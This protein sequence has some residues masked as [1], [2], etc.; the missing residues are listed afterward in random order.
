MDI[1]KKKKKEKETRFTI[2]NNPSKKSIRL[3][4]ILYNFKFINAAS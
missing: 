2:R 3:I 1:K 4:N